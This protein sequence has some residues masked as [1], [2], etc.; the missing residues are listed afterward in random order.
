MIYTLGLI[1]SY[2]SGIWAH[3]P[4]IKPMGRSKDWTR[5]QQKWSLYTAWKTGMLCISLLTLTLVDDVSSMHHL[6]FFLILY[7]L[8]SV[9]TFSTLFLIY[10]L[11]SRP[12]E[13]VKQ[14]RALLD[15]HFLY[16]HDP[17]GWFRGD[18]LRRN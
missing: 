10:S 14:S 9:R 2:C 17:S 3:A 7:T 11:R 16:S 6:S 1:T 5:E 18:I 13:F 8:T 15:D 4:P 12:R